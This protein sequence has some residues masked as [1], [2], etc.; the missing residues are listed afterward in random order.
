MRELRKLKG[1]K[2][3]KRPDRVTDESGVDSNQ[4]DGTDNV[5]HHVLV[6]GI[7]GV[8]VLVS[9][10]REGFSD[11]SDIGIDVF[12]SSEFACKISVC[13]TRLVRN[14]QNSGK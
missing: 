4:V 3:S 7:D 9:E 5:I 11:G 14:L 1:G 10:S 2:D 8:A 13:G 12:G 6:Q